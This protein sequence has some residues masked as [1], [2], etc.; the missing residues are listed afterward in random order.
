MSAHDAAV[1]ILQASPLGFAYLFSCSIA[2]WPLDATKSLLT[3]LLIMFPP[4]LLF[5]LQKPAEVPKSAAAAARVGP[6][7]VCAAPPEVIPELSIY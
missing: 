5:I 1:C 3:D 6:N 2:V 4:S 7:E